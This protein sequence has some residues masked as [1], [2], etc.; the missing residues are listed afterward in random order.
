M[1]GVSLERNGGS[2]GQRLRR[3][4]LAVRVVA[5]TMRIALR[6]LERLSP[7]AERTT[8]AQQLA[9]WVDGVLGYHRGRIAQLRQET[10]A[11]PGSI[12]DDP[13]DLIVTLLGQLES[14]LAEADAVAREAQQH[15]RA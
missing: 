5:V 6:E 14:A 12:R 4:L 10:A 15:A 7:S 9:T 11:M 8:W 3:E 2:L 1:R 13:P